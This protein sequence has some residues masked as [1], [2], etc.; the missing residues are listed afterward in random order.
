MAGQVE[1]VGL[2]QPTSNVDTIAF[3]TTAQ[4]L[5]SV[6]A[7]NIGAGPANISVWVTDGV[8]T[9]YIAS[10]LNL[11]AHNTYETFRFAMAPGDT[12]YVRSDTGD[13]TFLTQGIDQ[14]PVGA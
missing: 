1:R 2:L 10:Q 7:T 13:V 8:D 12:L 3:S 4:Y 5:L 11:T 14:T 6:I 9:A